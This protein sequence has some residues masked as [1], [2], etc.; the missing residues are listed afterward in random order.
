MIGNFYELESKFHDNSFDLFSNSNC[1]RSPYMSFFYPIPSIDEQ[2]NIE[3]INSQNNN[4]ESALFF[5]KDYNSINTNI[6]TGIKNN[7]FNKPTV[8][9]KKNP[10]KKRKDESGYKA[11]TKYSED[12]IIKKIKASFIRYLDKEL[13][14]SLR[15]AS[16]KKFYRLTSTIA[17]NLKKDDNIRLMNMTIRE[18][19]EENLT[20]GKNDPSVKDK[21]YNLI[22]EIFLN[23]DYIKT[24]EIL[25]TK[26]IDLIKTFEVKEFIC[27]ELEK[28]NEKLDDNV[29]YMSKLRNLL[30]HF[31]EWFTK[32]H[33]RKSKSKQDENNGTNKNN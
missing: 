23:N 32:K 30:E 29:A 10:G 8:P 15:F 1:D 16:A 5:I 25:S 7:D 14:N 4:L 11:H 2:Y 31:D 13:N 12:N 27:K 9:I 6:S 20:W 19:Y 33:E 18:I 22:Q 17:K 26:Y 28:K 21:N 3:L 24:K